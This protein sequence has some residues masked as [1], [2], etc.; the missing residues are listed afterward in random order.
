MKRNKI[1]IDESL[2]GVSNAHSGRLSKALD[3]A[4]IICT[5]I[6]WILYSKNTISLASSNVYL[7]GVILY[8]IL[9]IGQYLIATELHKLW[10]YGI[11]KR[12]KK[13]PHRMAYILWY[14]KTLVAGILVLYTY[15]LIN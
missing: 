11:L 1:Q 14:M 13:E 10:A 4:L 9:N 7:N 12:P 15:L 3:I 5:L 2:L 8:I 6:V